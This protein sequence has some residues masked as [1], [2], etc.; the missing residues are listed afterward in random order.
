MKLKNCM[1]SLCL[2]AA[3]AVNPMAVFAAPI[4][5]VEIYDPAKESDEIVFV[6]GEL[7]GSQSGEVETNTQTEEEQNIASQNASVFREQQKI[8]NSLVSSTVDTTTSV[9]IPGT[10]VLVREDIPITVRELT[11]Y[12][13]GG[14]KFDTIPGLY[15]IYHS[16]PG[17]EVSENTQKAVESLKET[18]LG[19]NVPTGSLPFQIGSDLLTKEWLLGI[20]T[21]GWSK[22]LIEAWRE[23]LNNYT[24]TQIRTDIVEG[25][26][27]D[28]PYQ[29]L[30]YE[31]LK[32]YVSS[33]SMSD[34]IETTNITEYRVSKEEKQKIISKNPVSEYKWEI[35]DKDGNLLKTTH[36]YGRTLRLSFSKAGTYYIRAYQKHYVTRADVVSTQKSEYWMISETRQL[37]WSSEMQGQQFTY[38]RND[39]EEFIETNYI[40]QEVTASMLMDN[41][42]FN[43]D[44]SGQL[45]IT[46][47]FQ[48]E[49]IK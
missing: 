35:Y 39:S 15:G 6:A 33:L 43:L 14:L 2:C 46:E 38:N 45:Q 34:L 19:D 30:R 1:L 13:T 18:I 24:W 28:W 8:R 11:K 40:Q 10:S 25:G 48:V 41:W 26:I 9:Y 44:P 27:I 29:E 16:Q 42:I 23:I 22:E 21:T 31:L 20:D 17:A 36:T 47:G 5:N 49:R 4:D 32:A 7:Q 37:L 3:I 12:I